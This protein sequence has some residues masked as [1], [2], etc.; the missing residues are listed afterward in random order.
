VSNSN[1][2]EQKKTA[3]KVYCVILIIAFIWN[4]AVIL[5]PVFLKMGGIYTTISLFMYSAFSNTCH[6]EEARSFALVGNSLAVCSRCTVIYLSFFAGS[7]IYPFVKRLNNTTM[8][9]LWLLFTV[10]GIMFFDAVS[11]LT[12]LY[13]NSFLTRSISGGLLGFVLTFYIIPGLINFVL[14][15]KFFFKPQNPDSA[16]SK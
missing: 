16:T 11:D 9:P 15:V 3:L 1:Y 4:S 7:I 14:E 6:Q 5:A 12:G 8:P 10:A 13:N 2:P